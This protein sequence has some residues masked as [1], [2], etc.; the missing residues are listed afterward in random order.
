[1][2]HD[3]GVCMTPEFLRQGQGLYDFTN[4]ARIV[5]GEYDKRS[6]NVLCDLYQSIN[7]PILRVDLGTAEMIK[8]ASNAFL[9]TKVTFIN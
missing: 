8:Y 5:V 7:A 9:A 4:P 1:M 6:G 3:F 2:G